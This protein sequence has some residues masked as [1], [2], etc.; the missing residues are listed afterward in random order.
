[1]KEALRQICPPPVWRVLQA[2]R[3]RALGASWLAPQPGEQ[4]LDVYWD[5]R[6]AALL[7]TW[8]EGNAWNEIQLLM[9]ALSGRVLDIACGTGKTIELLQRFPALE[10]HGCDI[11]DLLIAKAVQRGIPP[12][13]LTITDATAMNYPDGAFAWGYSIGSL[14]HFTEEGIGK[15]IAECHRVVSGST[16]HMIP[17]SRSGSNI[18]WIKTFQSYHNNSPAWWE[19]KC[20]A[21]YPHVNILDSTWADE[22]STGK[23]LICSKAP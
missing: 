19:A 20:R 11:S 10:V 12:E 17:V 5:P 6:M 9:A 18:G 22:I 23:W 2:V 15:F 14:E 8:G 13:R 1:M 3:A 7:E 16:F 4:D 21:T